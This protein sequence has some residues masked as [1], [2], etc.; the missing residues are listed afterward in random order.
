LHR[1]ESGLTD[2]VVSSRL[3]S[4]KGLGQNALAFALAD[5][6]SRRELPA[7]SAEFVFTTFFD[8]DSFLK[9]CP[10]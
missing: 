5:E 4:V 3:H 2:I 9:S 8:M 1:G 10:K 6:L 7:L